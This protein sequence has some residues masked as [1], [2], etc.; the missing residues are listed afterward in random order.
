MKT[1]GNTILITG[2]S[3]GIGLGFAAEFLKL[4]NKVI[5]CG[6]REERLKEVQQKHPG[7]IIKACDVA[8]A[9]D[10]EELA[11][12]TKKNHPEINV[13]INNAGVQLHANINKNADLG[14]IRAEVDTNL[15]APIH[16]SSLFIELLEDKGSAI[17]NITSGLAFVPLAFMPVYCATKAALHSITLSLR[18]QLKATSIKV[19]EI[20]PP[21]VDTELGHDTRQDKAQSHG[22]ISVEEFLKEAMEYIAGDVYESAVGIAKGLKAKREEAFDMMNK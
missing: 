6:R 15:I 19:F 3:S 5:I 2:G 21:A 16:L 13:L 20:A 11:A 10:R 4:G 18:H 14:K 17:I 8:N 12:W 9:A 22:G 1:T 7:I